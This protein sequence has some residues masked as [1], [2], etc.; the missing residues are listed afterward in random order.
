[1]LMG[2]VCLHG[3]WVTSLADVNPDISFRILQGMMEKDRGLMN[4]GSDG[5]FGIVTMCHDK[6]SN[7]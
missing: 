6:T 5:V 4:G 3:S 1:M 7:K 2:L